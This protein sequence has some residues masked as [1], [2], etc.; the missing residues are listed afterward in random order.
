MEPYRIPRL[1][2]VHVPEAR[3]IF[4]ALTVRENLLVGGTVLP[5]RRARDET[6]DQVWS[7]F[8]AL[9]E[10]ENVP[11]GSLSGGQQQM[12]A[13][14][15]AVMAHPRMILLDEPSLGLAPLIVR[16]L[17][18]R[19]GRLAETGVSILLVEQDVSL[20]LNF[21]DRAYVLENGTI[22]LEGTARELMGNDHI[23]RAYLGI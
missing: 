9:R 11:A 13:V 15:R 7:I 8:P 2:L 14:G 5:N 3:H 6:L 21:V 17:F 16:D 19:L 18:D 23:R 1:G 20:T 4:G 22:A 12:L 10:K